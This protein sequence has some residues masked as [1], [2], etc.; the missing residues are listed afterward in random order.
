MNVAYTGRR[1]VAQTVNDRI[2]DLASG[3]LI[4]GSVAYNP[5]AVTLKSDLDLVGILDF[6]RVDFKELYRRLSLDY[7]P[8]PA[9]Y[10]STERAN[11]F[12]IRWNTSNFEVG[13]HLWD[14]K[15]FEDIVELKGKHVMFRGKTPSASEYLISLD[16]QL[17][18]VSEIEEV[19]DGRLTAF[20]PYHESDGM[21]YVGTQIWNLLLDPV[22]L[23]QTEIDVEDKIKIFNRNLR[24]KLIQNFGDNPEG[25]SLFNALPEKVKQKI[26]LDLKQRLDTFFDSVTKS[27]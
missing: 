15:A 20:F 7:D 24:R 18:R 12:S 13:L 5:E 16:G 4:V 2:A 22:I 26:S 23:S 17:K 1:K 19:E 6:P 8:V 9:K 21:V 11:N 14:K 3:L 27:L 10:A 25:I